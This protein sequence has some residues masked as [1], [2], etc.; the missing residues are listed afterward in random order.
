MT[1]RIAKGAWVEI[2]NL[3][4]AP[5]ERAPRLPADT[6]GLPLEMWVKGFLAAP[7]A[8]GEEAEI[9]TAAGRRL[10]GTLCRSNP[11]Y[12]HGFGAPIPAL[13]GIGRELR[14]LLHKRGRFR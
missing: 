8:I 5:G 4:L 10:R 11:A 7:A 13:S 14:T 6:A 1:E 3:V 9:V 2:H 12:D